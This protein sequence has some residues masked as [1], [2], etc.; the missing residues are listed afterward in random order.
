MQELDIHVTPQKIQV[1]I[2]ILKYFSS[3]FEQLQLLVGETFIMVTT[4][5]GFLKSLHSKQNNRTERVLT[6]EANYSFSSTST[7]NNFTVQKIPWGHSQHV[8]AQ[9]KWTHL[10]NHNN[11]FIFNWSLLQQQKV[12]NTWILQKV[13]KHYK[14]NPCLSFLFFYQLLVVQ[15]V[16]SIN[17]ICI[18]VAIC[19]HTDGTTYIVHLANTPHMDR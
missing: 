7:I 17:A 11:P 3:D 1:F 12:N 15:S 14:W 8:L 19:K 13:L 5:Q 16:L 2:Y 10:A 18:M 4:Q 9:W 6:S